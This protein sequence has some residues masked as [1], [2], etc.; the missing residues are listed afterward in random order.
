MG[1]SNQNMPSFKVVDESHR[2]LYAIC[3][4]HTDTKPS[5]CINRVPNNGK[6]KG[7]FYCFGCGY[8]GE[9]TPQEVD[10]LSKNIVPIVITNEQEPTQDW[11]AKHHDYFFKEFTE[12][13]GLLLAE[14]WNVSPSVISELAIGWD[15]HAHTIP[16]YD[17]D[18]IVGIQRQFTYGY[19]CM[20]TGSSLGLIIPTTMATGNVLFMPEGCSDLACI[21][22]MGFHG[23]GR[24]NALVGKSLV[25][26][27]LHRYNPVYD[28]II[29]MADNDPSG[30]RGAEELQDYIDSE[31]SRTQI[32]VPYVGKDLRAMI[33]VA[34]KQTTK[35]KLQELITCHT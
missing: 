25:Y 23:I 5:L 3:P 4:V 8:F 18:R 6:P 32:Y 35:L 15:G 1:S 34:G 13:K 27:W 12:S 31:H 29:I 7:F 11:N 21:L 26:K 16:M 28:Q 17:L 2:F 10:R 20:L 14:K 33:N 30:I 9:I 22:D 19:K 24:P